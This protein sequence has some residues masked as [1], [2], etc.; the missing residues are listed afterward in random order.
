MCVG[1]GRRESLVSDGAGL[2]G[3][4]MVTSVGMSLWARWNQQDQ[5]FW[6]RESRSS[7]LFGE[8]R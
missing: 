6:K 5:L 8:V 4:G 2:G 7:L 1:R 3:Q